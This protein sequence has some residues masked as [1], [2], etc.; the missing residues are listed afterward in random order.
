MSAPRTHPI[1]ALHAAA[2]GRLSVPERA[3]LDAHLADCDACR[4]ELRAMT[5]LAKQVG[6]A[7][8]E[9]P[10]PGDLEARLRHALDEEDRRH[11]ATASRDAAVPPR[12][13][14]GRRVWHWG[15]AA[16][17][18]AAALVL[19]IIWSERRPTPTAPV[20]VADDFRRFEAG[21]L[22]LPTRTSEPRELERALAAASLGFDTRVFD[23]GMMAFQ[24]EG[25]GVHRVSGA[26]S[27]LFAYRGTEALRLLCQMYLGRITDLPP[28][29]A[30]RT[31][32][33]VEFLVYRVGEVTVVFWQ[34]G[35]VVCALA[36]NGDAEAAV[37]LAL[38]KAVRR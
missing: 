34:E 35:D 21:E 2:A 29:D 1:E 12:P 19:T 30:R 38:A 24:L 4:R 37:S 14:R 23:F 28:P 26:P 20:E 36:A 9:D 11:A 13:V 27:A 22:P 7:L 33:G 6:G 25:G 8:E 15:T 32:D 17:A 5:M 10:V 3:A 31:N 18:L 16:A